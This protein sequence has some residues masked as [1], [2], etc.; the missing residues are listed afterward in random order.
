M[1]KIHVSPKNYNNP[2]FIGLITN[3][4]KVTAEIEIVISREK[5][6]TADAAKLN[7]NVDKMNDLQKSIAEK[8]FSLKN[9]KAEIIIAKVY[10]NPTGFIIMAHDPLDFNI[11]NLLWNELSEWIYVN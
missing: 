5:K 11:I 6:V 9:T 8:L 7:F 10:F 2:R 3:D 1:E 4:E